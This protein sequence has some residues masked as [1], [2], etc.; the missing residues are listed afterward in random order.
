MTKHVTRHFFPILAAALFAF[1][2]TG[3]ATQQ[4]QYDYTA[5][6]QSK[7]RSVIILPPINKSPDVKATYSMLSQM[8]YPLAEAGYYVFPVAVVDETFKQN[9]L[10]V[11]NDIQ[12]V[13]FQKLREIFGADAALYVTVNEYG[14]KYMVLDSASIV[15]V[16]A[17][18]VDLKTGKT[19][20]EGTA[21]ASNSEGGNNSGGGLV[22]MLVAA[23]VKQV[24]NTALDAAHPVAG[25]ASKRLLSAGR[26]NSILYG[27]YSE[28][29]GTD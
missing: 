19:L 15:S 14:T 24:L 1:I 21:S 22:G 25:I 9:G 10:T 7:P 17:S 5:F 20:W 29:Y 16:T 27:P 28:K 8:T 23:A 3:C 2:I 11:A 4:A 18:L 12:D 13:P 26:P 6:K